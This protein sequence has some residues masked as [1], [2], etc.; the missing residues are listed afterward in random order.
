MATTVE[1]IFTVMESL[2]KLLEEGEDSFESDFHTDLI[3]DEIAKI[4]NRC[5]SESSVKQD[6]VNS[7]LDKV[8]ENFSEKIV[9]EEGEGLDNG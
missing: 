9:I 4:I 8:L 3:Y 6:D 7:L 1:E 5:A 2:R